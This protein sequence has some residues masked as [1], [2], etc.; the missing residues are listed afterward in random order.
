MSERSGI[1]KKI[2]IPKAVESAAKFVS[3]FGIFISTYGALSIYSWA[4]KILQ[5]SSVPHV[6]YLIKTVGFS[7]VLSANSAVIALFL[8]RITLSGLLL[9]SAY[10]V[11]RIFL[12]FISW[13]GN[14]NSWWTLVLI[15]AYGGL[16]WFTVNLI[17]SEYSKIVNNFLGYNFGGGFRGGNSSY[18]IIYIIFIAF[19][20]FLFY[21]FVDKPSQG[22]V[23]DGGAED[24]QEDSGGDGVAEEGSESQGVGGKNEAPVSDADAVELRKEK[25]SILNSTVKFLGILYLILY[26]PFSGILSR[27]LIPPT[28]LEVAEIKTEVLIEQYLLERPS[29]PKSSAGWSTVNFIPVQSYPDK[30]DILILGIEENSEIIIPSNPVVVSVE[31]KD[32]AYRGPSVKLDFQRFWLDRGVLYSIVIDN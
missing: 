6:S 1:S 21:L 25:I 24:T 17:Y 15:F 5:T 16:A 8:I 26:L 3:L 23:S 14:L 29:P 13:R 2:D 22:R 32:M 19:M 11:F 10:F 7:E 18:V 27:S 12:S 4:S 28:G 31:K 20:I 9:L 30:I